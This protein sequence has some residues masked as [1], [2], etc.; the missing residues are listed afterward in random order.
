MASVFLKNIIKNLCF[1]FLKRAVEI[2]LKPCGS[3]SS[4]F[5][6]VL[7]MNVIVCLHYLF[8][9]HGTANG[10]SFYIYD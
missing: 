8:I 9:V 6:K 1:L 10:N 5:G 3:G 4:F 7:I 2:L